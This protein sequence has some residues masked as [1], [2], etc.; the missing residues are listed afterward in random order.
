[1]NVS[2]DIQ[3]PRVS[4]ATATYDAVVVG[5][6]PYGLS[7]AAHLL[8]RGLKIAVFGKP[9]Q[10]WRDSMPESML[11][12]S[13]WWATNLSD[14]LKRYK[15][16]RYFQVQQMTVQ[17]PLPLEVFV[18]YGL[19]FQR[20]AVP[21]VDETFVAAIQRVGGEFELLLED[22]RMIRSWAV[23]MA[24]GLQYYAY[25]PEQYSHLPPDL[26]SHTSAH[27]SFKHFAGKRVIV[28]GGGQS[29]L[30]TA[31]FLYESDAQVDLISRS[32][33]CWLGEH[34]AE[35]RRS[36]LERIRAPMAGIAPGWFNWGLEHAPYT[37][38]MLPRSV[39]DRLLR[40]RGR[41]GPAGSAWLQPRVLGK[42]G[43]HEGVMVQNIRAMKKSVALEL[44]SGQV[45][46]AIHIVL[47]TGYRV[48]VNRLPMLGDGLIARIRT[49]HDAP[50]LNNQFESSV[51]GL[52]FVGISSVSS[53]GPLYR[54]VVGTDAAASRV[55]GA[56]AQKIA[57]VKER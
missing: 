33:L 13:Y 40:G 29:A 15:L 3:K 53:C 17:D 31:A 34:S 11:L 8:G 19:W 5:A 55:A 35:D 20:R 21:D 7:V 54:F 6:G 50:V 4:A 49:Y 52:Y 43:L 46:N 16:A 14:P 30:E 36:L 24:P 38:Q 44:S 22:E 28:I 23:V 45:L 27:T 10:F 56:I 41:Y 37:F 26:V 32:P 18:D 2:A 47:A 39:K 12:R 51:P 1:M 42:V 48:N 9:L 57:H 25:C